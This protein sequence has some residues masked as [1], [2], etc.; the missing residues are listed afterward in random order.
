MKLSKLKHGDRITVRPHCE[1]CTK[2]PERFAKKKEKV[3]TGIDAL[4]Q[5]ILPRG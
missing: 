1:D 2:T 3:L 4:M 5:S